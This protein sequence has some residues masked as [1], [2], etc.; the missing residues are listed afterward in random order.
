MAPDARV[1]VMTPVKDARP[2]LDRY[3]ELLS[4]LTYP[5]PLLS[6]ALLESDSSD[7]TFDDL[8][9]RLVALRARYR[10]V[11]V[12]K[13]DFGF[14][15]P[16]D[17]HRWAPPMQIPRRTVLAKSR[18]H[19]L[20]RGLDDEDWVLWL[21]VDVDDYPPDIVEQLLAT[22]RDIVQPHCVRRY[23]GPTFDHNAWREHGRVHLED[24]R[25]GPDLVRLDAVGGTMLLVNA[26]RHRDGLVFPPFLYGRRSRYARDP[27]PFGADEPGEI[28]TE[29]LGLMAKDMGLECW[30]LPHVEI[31]HALA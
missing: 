6:L 23:G 9:R 2:H 27:N 17:A 15:L 14:A 25:G 22:R 24:L 5:A 4:A 12:W 7:G 21:D 1:V 19:L 28:E 8:Q 20:S 3:F 26:D 30:G 11:D 10:R 13:R 29:G 18:N 31:R 16:P